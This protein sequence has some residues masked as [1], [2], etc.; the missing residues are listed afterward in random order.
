MPGTSHGDCHQ[1]GDTNDDYL[2]QGN[3]T[4]TFQATKEVTAGQHGNVVDVSAA[5]TFILQRGGISQI[6]DF[7]SGTD[8]L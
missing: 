4:W 3:E 2:V 6:A 5:D 7:V 8:E 1:S